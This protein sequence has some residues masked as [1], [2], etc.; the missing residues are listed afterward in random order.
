[1]ITTRGFDLNSFCKEMDDY[2]CN[3]LRGSVT[4]DDMFCDIYA[5][6]EGDDPMSEAAWRKSNPW[7]F[8]TERGSRQLR[9]DAQTA[10]DMG[11]SDLRDFLTKCVN[12]WVDDADDTFV[13]PSDWDARGAGWASTCRAGAT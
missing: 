4:A 6:D 13:R 1:M 8:A 11:G 3:V 2:A 5:P 9:S 10:R 12:I 7:S